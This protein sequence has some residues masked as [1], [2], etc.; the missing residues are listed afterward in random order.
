MR[1]RCWSRKREGIVHIDAALSRSI[2]VLGH[3]NISLH[4]PRRPPWIF[5]YPIF[6][7]VFL[8]ITNRQHPVVQLNTAFSREYALG[9][10]LKTIRGADWNR[11][12][13]LS[14]CCFKCHFALRSNL[15]AIFDLPSFHSA[16][17]V[18]APL[19]SGCVPVLVLGGYSVVNDIPEG[20]GHVASFTGVVSVLFRAVQQL[21]LW[22]WDQFIV[23]LEVECLHGSVGR[24]S[25]TGST[26]ALVFYA[27]YCSLLQPVNLCRNIIGGS[28]RT[29][30]IFGHG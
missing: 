7:P 10:E 11:D 4:S 20:P 29:C 6:L 26:T 30:A 23:D 2:P 9:V 25:P 12:R 19:I 28:L 13:I 22:K 17:V 1:W 16:A 3:P 8:P 18:F 24:K 21:L 5:N 15:S 27:C 14:N